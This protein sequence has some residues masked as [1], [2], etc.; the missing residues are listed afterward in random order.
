MTMKLR[1]IITSFIAAIAILA[2]CTPE[3]VPVSSL[4]GLEVSNDYFSL[5][6]DEGSTVTITVTGDEP[7]TINIDPN[8]D[9][10]VAEPSSGAAGQTVNVT[11]RSLTA[12]SATRKTEVKI[13]M[14]GKTKILNVQQFAVQGEPEYLTVK[15]ALDLIYSDSYSGGYVYV[16]GI[17]CKIVEISPSYGNA[18]YFLSDDG[19]YKE[20]EW[21]E[22]YRG[23]WI[24]GE[25]FTEGDEFAIGDELTIYS[26]LVLYNG[27]TPETNQYACEVVSIKKSL[28]DVEPF[29]FEQLPYTDTTF[30]MVVSAKESPLL[31]TTDSDWLRVVDINADGSYKL[32]ASENPRTGKRTASI[33]VKGPTALKSVEVVQAG[34]PSSGSSITEVIAAEDNDQV[35]TLPSTL[36]VA[37]TSNGAVLS[38]GNNAVFAYGNDAAKLKIGDGVSISATKTTY[39]GVP[40]LKDFGAADIFIDSEGNTVA[41]PDAKDITGQLETYAA[42]TAEYIKFSGTLNVSAD[43]KYYNMDLD[44]IDPAVRQGSIYYPAESLDAKSWNGKKITVTG[45]FNGISGKGKFVNI[46]ATKIA[47]YVDNPKGTLKNPYEATELANLIKGGNIPEGKVYVR[48]IINKIDNINLEKKNAQYWLSTDGTTA[49]F[50]AYR[51]YYYGGADWTAENQDAIKVGDEV[52]LYGEPTYYAQ[53]DVAEFK[54]GNFLVT[55]NGKALPEGDGTA[56][57]PYN[58]TKLREMLEAGETFADEVYAKG[59]ISQIDNVKLDKGTAQYW[60]SDDGS[61]LFQMEV[62]SGRWFNG[63]NFTSEDQIALG[64][65]VVVFG[66]VKMYK[67]T[68]EFD[69]NNKIISLNGKTE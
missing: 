53:N 30:N 5:T 25:N 42:S 56:A 17:V 59:I 38:D 62:Y 33:S 50:E 35:K 7:W 20:G 18:T 3:L 61:K 31:V 16:T 22:V 66:K 10:L 51:S 15:E 60:I 19:T 4:D 28:I 64:D 2:G 49:D 21:L 8:C 57:S 24:N 26:S 39:N 34:A 67:T 55:I 14:G 37:L 43:G 52:V 44:G 12:A 48:G 11:F 6:A 13:A 68:A 40:E 29:T 46:I 32:E 41:Y 69:S 9:W 63:A 36:V 45:Y 58:V 54:Q 23:K 65:E 47:E 27:V 1:Y